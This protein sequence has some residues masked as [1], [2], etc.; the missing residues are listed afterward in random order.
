MEAQSQRHERSIRVYTHGENCKILVAVPLERM[1]FECDR[2][3]LA[4]QSNRDRCP[5]PPARVAIGRDVGHYSIVFL[6]ECFQMVLRRPLRRGDV[7]SEP[8][9]EA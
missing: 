6:S 1:L 9:I 4:R 3:V 5:D 7:G 2:D 8:R